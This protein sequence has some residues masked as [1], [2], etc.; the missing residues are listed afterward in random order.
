M[1]RVA[2][3]ALAVVSGGCLLEHPPRVDPAGAAVETRSFRLDGDVID[4]WLHRDV[5]PGPMVVL[6]TGDGG[7]R[8]TDRALFDG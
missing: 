8:G 7:W 3:L 4:V 2:L 1:G 5:S 6:L